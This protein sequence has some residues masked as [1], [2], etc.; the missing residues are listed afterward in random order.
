V[1]LLA[2]LQALMRRMIDVAY[3]PDKRGDAAQGAVIPRYHD[4]TI[5][6]NGAMY[7]ALLVSSPRLATLIPPLDREVD[8]LLDEAMGKQWSRDGF[9]TERINIGRLAAEYLRAARSEAGL[10]HIELSSVWAW[11]GQATG[12]PSEAVR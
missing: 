10:P 12:T 11:H 5:S 2:S 3:L 8:R 7:E 6:W 1:Q 4:A 9:R